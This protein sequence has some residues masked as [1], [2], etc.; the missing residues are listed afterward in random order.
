MMLFPLLNVILLAREITTDKTFQS[1]RIVDTE[2]LEINSVS[3]VR[4][5]VFVSPTATSVVASQ[6]GKTFNIAQPYAFAVTQATEFTVT[7]TDSVDIVVVTVPNSICE[8][9]AFYTA[10]G[11]QVSMTANSNYTGTASYC[12]FSPSTDP[13]G[14]T[15]N[16]GFTSRTSDSSRLF[17]KN[18]DSYSTKICSSKCNK[19]LPDSYYFVEYQKESGFFG[20]T[21]TFTRD[22]KEHD[23]EFTDCRDGQIQYIPSSSLP[24]P[25]DIWLGSSCFTKD[26]VKRILVIVFSVLGAVA[27]LVIVLLCACGCCV[28]CG[29]AGCCAGMC[30]S[31]QR[32]VVVEQPI[33]GYENPP[34]AGNVYYPGTPQYTYPQQ[35]VYPEPGVYQPQPGG[36]WYQQG[37]SGW[38]PQQQPVYGTTN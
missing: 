23:D 36:G 2:R 12:V 24:V 6:N 9:G 34:A 8:N 30:K 7:T 20:G 18:Y 27:F 25:Y 31:T 10:G 33:Y 26:E 11:K 17:Y 1:V 19:K 5:F 22:S 14:V 32:E 3:G 37:Q 15:V 21:L 35:G 28:S 4:V 16:W 13:Q 38:Y 29:I